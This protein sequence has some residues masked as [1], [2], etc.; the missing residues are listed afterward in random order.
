VAVLHTWGQTLQHHPHVHCLATGGGLAVDND[1]RVVEPAR[2]VSCRPGFFLDVKVLGAVY[3]EKFLAGLRQAY[4][5]GR[6]ELH[7]RLA[8]LAEPAAFA[9]LLQPLHEQPWVVYCKPPFAG[10]E[11]T[12]K[13][14][15]RGAS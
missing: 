4:A 7:G 5:Q 2:W 12:L 14:T 3:Q 8:S 13:Y 9:A 11:V 15:R 10:P 1:G 6:L